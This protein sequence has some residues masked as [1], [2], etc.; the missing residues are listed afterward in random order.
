MNIPGMNP[1]AA[2]TL[3]A[4]SS[5]NTVQKILSA[6]PQ[7][8]AQCLRLSVPFEVSANVFNFLK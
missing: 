5:L 2:M 4:S 8:I 1:R 6:N 7:D 3:H